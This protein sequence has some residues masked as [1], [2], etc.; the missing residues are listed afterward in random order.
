[1]KDMAQATTLQVSSFSFNNN[2][3]IPKQYTCDGEDINPPLRIDNIPEKAGSLVIMMEDPDAPD[4]TFTHWM[5]WDAPPHPNI[6]ENSKPDGTVGRND[7]GKNSYKGPCPPSGEEHRYFYKVYTL[8]SKV[9]LNPGSTREALMVLVD[10][11]TIGYGEL[12]GI[13]RK[14]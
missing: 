4:G 11:K 13:Y 14:D 8:D 7:F 6:E 9:N 5:V 10:E 3:P 1:M 2:E 12:M